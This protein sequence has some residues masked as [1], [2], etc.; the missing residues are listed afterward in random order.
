M[1]ELST[2]T[3]LLVLPFPIKYSWAQQ[4]ND[5]LQKVEQNI[6]HTHL[7][8]YYVTFK[9]IHANIEDS[10]YK[11]SADIWLKRVPDDSI[12]GAYFHVKGE[13]SR[14]KYDYFYDG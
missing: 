9:S 1:K 6:R 13:G 10:I 5:V 7:L 3:F 4:V 12:F 8:F 2:I 11:A 14:G